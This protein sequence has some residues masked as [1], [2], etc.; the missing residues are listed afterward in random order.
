MKPFILIVRQPGS[1]PVFR[2]TGGK[3]LFRTATIDACL[4]FTSLYH[5]YSRFN[6]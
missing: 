2:A 6:N 5:T 3:S 4:A 1:T